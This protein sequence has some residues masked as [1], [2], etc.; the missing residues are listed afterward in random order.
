MVEKTR[1]LDF[2]VA[3]ALGL[4]TMIAAGIFSLSGK[5]VYEIGSS[6][7]IAFIYRSGHR[8]DDGGD[9]SPDRPSNAQR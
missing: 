6:A 4:G 8:W 9:D 2:R 5:A 1:T 3:F 7:V